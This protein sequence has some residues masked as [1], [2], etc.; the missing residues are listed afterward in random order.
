MER[1]SALQSE[2]TSKGVSI[3]EP[4]DSNRYNYFLHLEHGINLNIDKV[5]SND[6]KLQTPKGEGGDRPKKPY[7]FESFDEEQ[8]EEQLK[9]CSKEHGHKEEVHVVQTTILIV[10]KEEIVA[11][12]LVTS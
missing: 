1:L 4:K 9:D 6:K 2:E 3:E 7:E 10:A 5:A 8:D 11:L 12:L